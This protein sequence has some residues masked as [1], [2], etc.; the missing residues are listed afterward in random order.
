MLNFY[1]FIYVK[2]YQTLA[3]IGHQ[4]TELDF[5]KNM[6]RVLINAF[7]ECRKTIVLCKTKVLRQS[8][9]RS[10]FNVLRLFML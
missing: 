1:D 2:N 5:Y 10:L 4:T 3:A 7:K 6:A 8:E 9:Y